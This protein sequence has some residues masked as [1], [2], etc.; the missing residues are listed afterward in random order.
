MT[1]QPNPFELIS[2][3]EIDKAAAEQVHI[4]GDGVVCD[5][6]PRYIPGGPEIVVDASAGIIP[7]WEKNTTLRWRFQERSLLQFR[8]PEATKTAMRGLFDRAVL[9]WG[10]AAPIAF[11][12]QSQL[13]DFEIVFRRNDDCFGG[14]CVLA[15]A[16][17]PQPIRDRLVIY[18]Q[19]L[20]RSDEAQV[21]TLIHEIG[22]IFGLR[23]FFAKIKETDAPSEVFG[24][25]RSVSIM[26]YGSLSQLT[27]DDKTDLKR[28]YQMVWD[29]ELTQINRVPIKLM[30]AFHTTF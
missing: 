29:G 12:E 4:F 24:V 3:A 30:K 1:N 16:F 2:P 18:P 9:A 19:M 13:W 27:N 26:N 28:L 8:N 11:E 17:F 6:E 21:N 23:H 5:I 25:N 15:S 20:A 7:L 10:D 22:H 14:G